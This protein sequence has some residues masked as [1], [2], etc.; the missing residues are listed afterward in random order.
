MDSIV[1]DMSVGYTRAMCVSA[2]TE[3]NFQA[4]AVPNKCKC[5]LI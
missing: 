3:W 4:D 2:L 1:T 5:L